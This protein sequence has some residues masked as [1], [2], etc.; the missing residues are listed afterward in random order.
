MKP[1]KLIRSSLIGVIGVAALFGLVPCS[2]QNTAFPA[3]PPVPV[4]TFT[5]EAQRVLPM[6]LAERI[7]R[8]VVP[9]RG[10]VSI[11]PGV[12][13]NDLL[14]TG[15]GKMQLGI[16]GNPTAEE[17]GFK[18]ER[19][20]L[21]WPAGLEAPKISSAL[22][23]VRKQ[24]LQGNY[25]EGLQVA[26]KAAADAGYKP[27]TASH[28]QLEA[29]VMKV[30]LPADGGIR[31]YLRSVDFE[32]GEVKVMWEDNRG[33]WVRSAFVSRPDNVAVQLLTPPQGKLLSTTIEIGAG[34]AQ[35]VSGGRGGRG[36]GR[37]GMMG[38]SRAALA[39]VEGPAT[40]A[41]ERDFSPQRLIVMNRFT[42]PGAGNKGWAAVVRVVQDGGSSAIENGAL[43][44]KDAKSVLLLTRLEWYPDFQRRTV[45]AMVSSLN[46]LAPDYA[47]LL[48]KAQKAQSAIFDRASLDFPAT[49]EERAM[50][51]EELLANQKLHVGY[52][53][54]LLSRLFDMGRYWQMLAS[55][56]FPPMYGNMNIDVNLQVAGGNMAN[57]PE[58]M[59]AFFKWIEAV[60]P[61]ARTNAKNIFGARGAL[62]SVYPDHET[63]ALDTVDASSPYH[64]WV[65]AGGW[66]YGAFWDRYLVTGDKGFLRDRVM[67]GLRELGLFYEDYLTQKDANGNYIF[68]PSYSPESTPGSGRGGGGGRGGGATRMGQVVNASIDIMVC[69]EVLNHLIEGAA[70][71]GTDADKVPVWKSLLAA[72]PPY[73]LEADGA[74]KEWASPA[75]PES[76]DRQYI[77]HEYGVW[78]GDDID[79][80]RTPELAKAEWLANRKRAQ[81]DAS[82]HG[83]S[84][85]MLAAARLKDDHLVDFELKQLLQ[86]GYV[87]P[88]LTTTGRSYT[89]DF[90]PDQ[91]GSIL[92]A[93]M[94]MLVY[95]RE[96]VIELL[97]AVPDA[98]ERGSIKGILSRSFAKLDNLTWDLKARTVDVT[99]TSLRAQDVTL[100]DRHG[101]ESVTA[102]ASVLAAQPKAD[103]TSCVLHL[104]QHQ[105]VTVHLKLGAH[106]PSD[107]ILALAKTK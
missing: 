67:P 98:L 80:D 77:S 52:N 39:P 93:L 81:G 40:M 35:P 18:Q 51:S 102:P 76:I 31:N 103:A 33:A 94:E 59:D 1:P 58:S 4:E 3:K 85:R 32:S 45:E 104:P 68:V 73:L 63:G 101:I 9:A 56:D 91:Q 72:M 24:I 42:Q 75:V 107:W 82:G 105:A 49:A 100:I 92:T 12:G 87:G 46:S 10:M 90:M 36:G 53:L 38:S 83:L 29:F 50:S 57:L 2:A 25:S 14:L 86:T 69:R 65:S 61:D 30:G 15:N 8:H 6:P 78:P 62:F 17:I 89:A 21:P 99:L 44:V 60:L 19:I 27:G 13:K 11:A 26:A 74:L 66:A 47:A 48:A 106:K 7:K 64:Y 54:T 41:G 43:V 79:P 5:P 20:Q 70:V 95:S 37:G 23:E 16:G 71:L 55:G 96:G 84:H 22:P 97:P 88:V 34:R 28:E